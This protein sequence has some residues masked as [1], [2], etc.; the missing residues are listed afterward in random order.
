[1]TRRLMMISI[2]LIG[3]TLAF[4]SNAW[5]DH[6]RGKRGHRSDKDYHYKYKSH[7]KHHYGWHKGKWDLKRDRY[8][9]HRKYRH[10]DH[11][12]RWDR[13]RHRYRYYKGRHHHKRVVEKHVYHHGPRR[14]RHVEKHV[15]HHGPKRHRHVEKHVY[16]HYPKR[17]RYDDDHSKI[18]LILIDQIL[19]VAVAVSGTH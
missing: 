14:H 10:R 7:P 19:G 16:H 18:S 12:R 17:H 6:D 15:Y 13:D 8:K 11:D 5:A 4:G 2:A 1:M 3:F 9:H